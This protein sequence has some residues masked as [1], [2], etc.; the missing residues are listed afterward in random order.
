V[1]VLH[2]VVNR[3]APLMVPARPDSIFQTKP[4]LAC[5]EKMGAER[6][7]DQY[8][9]EYQSTKC[10]ASAHIGLFGR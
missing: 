2:S 8:E 3:T 9:M 10:A 1:P 4:M 5:F 7:V 6:L